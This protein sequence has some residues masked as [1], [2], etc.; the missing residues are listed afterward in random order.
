MYQRSWFLLGEVVQQ[1][2]R[3]TVNLASQTFNF[4]LIL[5]SDTGCWIDYLALET[6]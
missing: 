5:S 2:T 4:S 1:M 3:G 6:Q